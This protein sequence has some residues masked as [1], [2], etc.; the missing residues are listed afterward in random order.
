MEATARTRSH[1]ADDAGPLPAAI[2]ALESLVLDPLALPSETTGRFR[3]LIVAAFVMA[4]GLVGDW[5][6][7]PWLPTAF[8]EATRGAFVE[9]DGRMAFREG[10]DLW[11]LR[12]L[13]GGSEEALAEAERQV[14]RLHVAAVA[15]PVFLLLAW[16]TYRLIPAWTVWRLRSRKLD[17]A[18][19]PHLASELAGLARLAGA[20]GAIEWHTRPGFL[21]GLA[22]GVSSR[23]K[24][25]VCGDPRRLDRGLGE[26][27]RAVVL[28]EL[29]HVANR[30]VEIRDK[31]RAAWAVLGLFAAATP[32]MVVGHGGSWEGLASVGLRLAACGAL[33][34]A[35]WTG[36]VRSREHMA[37][38]RVLRWGA[39][40]PL[41]RR[42]RLPETAASGHL[43]AEKAPVV[44]SALGRLRPFFAAHPTHSERLRVLAEPARLFRVS[45]PLAFSTGALLALTVGHLG[46]VVVHVAVVAFAPI[47]AVLLM[48]GGVS[49]AFLAPAALVLAAALFIP[50]THWVAGALG[51]Q[52]LRSALADLSGGGVGWGYRGLLLPALAFMAGLELGLWLTPLGAAGWGAA[53]LVAVWLCAFGALVWLWLIQVRALGRLVLGTASEGA[54]ATRAERRLRILAVTL[55]VP[56]IAPAVLIRA[57]LAAAANLAR[58]GEASA[59]GVERETLAMIGVEW[60]FDLISIAFAGAALLGL[61]ALAVVWL[62]LSHRIPACRRCG[63]IF[64]SLTSVGLRCPRC[65]EPAA[66][67]L[68]LR[69]PEAAGDEWVR[70]AG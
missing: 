43:R 47:A 64:A 63:G 69:K 13:P 18:V 39:G 67:W 41:S 59:F 21:D 23:P 6:P 10:F 52:V 56:V 46:L 66:A 44:R 11:A 15:M 9:R 51:V 57:I 20:E 68:Y 65:S 60:C 42:L 14:R 34:L 58:G 25:I 24:V 29:G 48:G 2:P 55:L 3:M 54:E 8:E 16:V 36:L 27:H 38:W 26:A 45:L 53:P 7:T 40:G 28:H 31:A 5:V 33:G 62:R 70:G 35:L 22:C 30:D 19:A 32:V 4:W 1:V 12:D 61:A 50:L 37:D 49:G 17:A